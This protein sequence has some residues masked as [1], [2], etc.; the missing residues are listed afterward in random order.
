VDRHSRRRIIDKG[1]VAFQNLPGRWTIK[2]NPAGEANL[3]RVQA[4][5]EAVEPYANTPKF[6][7]LVF[8]GGADRWPTYAILFTGLC[9]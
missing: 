3:G 2:D 9:G 7:D 6:F 4:V 8:G 5:L 1:R